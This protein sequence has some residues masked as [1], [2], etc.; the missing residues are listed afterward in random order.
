VNGERGLL[1]HRSPFSVVLF[2]CLLVTGKVWAQG[3]SLTRAFDLERRGSFAQAADLYRSV[4]ATKPGDVSALL[5]LERSLVPLNRLPEILPQVRAALAANPTAAPIYGVA[6]RAYSSANQ[7]DSL[8]SAVAQWAKVAPGDETPFREWGAAALARHDRSTARKA[9]TMGREKLGRPDAL[10]A[11]VAQLAVMD[12]DWSGAAREWA[13]ATKAMPGY[14]PSAISSLSEAPR[15]THDDIL[16]QLDKEDS[17]E[18][19]RLS[20]ALRARWGDPLGAFNSL[21]ENLPQA[22]APAIEAL[23]QFLEQAKTQS[24]P[25]AYKAQ[26][27]A[28]EALAERW[29]GAPQKARFRLDAARAYASAGDRASARRML[30]MIAEDPVNAPTVTAGASA[31][32]VGLLVDEGKLDDASKRLEEYRNLL[33]VD[34]YQGLRRQIAL[35]YGR[36]GA[37]DRGLAMLTSDSTVEGMAAVGRIQLYRG[38]IKG[39]SDA[40]RAAGPF[41]GDRAQATERTALLAVLQPIDAESLPAL[42][43]AF[44]K[45]DSGD[46]VHAAAAFEKLAADLPPTGGGAELKLLAGRIQAALKQPIPAEQLFRAAIVKDAPAT[47]AAASLELSRLLMDQERPS[48]AAI[49][50]E[51]MILDYP[52]SALVP[53]ARRLLDQARGATPKT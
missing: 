47:A 12:E 30:T 37:P 41:A 42:G 35:G 22:S 33:P 25:D 6:L 51:R 11:E 44:A 10:A 31:T 4:L 49:M 38:D 21:M 40:F 20:V 1:I 46:S 5:G 45:L 43:S 18:A 16:K 26:G 19:A 23:Q 50:L 34:E 9:Y 24:T 29:S 2:L 39:A 28:L 8:E 27:K 14:R 3:E 32:L 7:L 48:E 36:T 17:P 53:Q 13:R 52:T 15:K